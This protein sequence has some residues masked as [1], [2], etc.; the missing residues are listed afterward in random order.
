MATQKEHIEEIRRTRFSIGGDPN[1]LTEDLHHAVRYLSAEL[2]AKDVHFL[3]ELIQVHLLFHH[4]L[5]TFF[6]VSI[7]NDLKYILIS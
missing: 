4:F 3:M 1:P 7:I 6:F 2:Y 5:F